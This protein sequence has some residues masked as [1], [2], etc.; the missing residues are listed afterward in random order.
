MGA[1][2]RTI[3]QIATLRQGPQVLP[4]S[5]VLLWLA[6]LAHWLTG[7]VLSLYTLPPG[8][9]MLS[10]M[11]GTLIMVALVHMLMV[12]HRLQHRFVQTVTALAACEAMLG[13]LA[14]PPTAWF[15]MGGDIRD[16]AAM[17]SLLLL[18]WNI[19]IAAHIFRHALNITL[20]MGFLFSVGYTLVSISLGSMIGPAAN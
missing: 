14:I 10:A 17:L 20:G 11:I 15:F 18:G 5:S 8:E 19:T 7:V 16:I 4:P 3:W 6:L 1:L 2:L 13:L 9:S 12:L